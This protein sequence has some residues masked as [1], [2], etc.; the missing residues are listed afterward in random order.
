MTRDIHQEI[1]DRFIAAIEAG[2]KPWQADW[3]TTGLPLRVTGQAYQ[4]INTL[5]LGMIGAAK[6]YRN[7]TWMT[8]DQARK[9]GGCVRKGEKG[10][11]VVFYKQYDKNAAEDDA[12]AD[13][14]G[15][16][17]VRVLRG[18]T[19]FN[20]EQID[21][22]P[23]GK[24]AVA[25]PILDPMQ[26]DNDAESALR[27][28]GAD[29]REGGDRAYFDILADHVQLPEFVMFKSVGGYLATMA[30]ELVHWTGHKSRLGR[31]FGKQFGDATYA[32]EELV[33]EIGAAFVCARLGIAGDHFESHAAYVGSWLKKL[34]SDKKAIFRAAAL[35][36]AAADLVLA[37][38]MPASV[39]QD[40]QE[41]EP[42]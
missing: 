1:T 19:V 23:E 30:H 11:P 37:N 27:S 6:G 36:Q 42:A 22:L 39:D 24:F 7:P 31:E 3:I 28:C 14:D 16:V 29:I 4:G 41:V 12:R 32:F 10:S 5:L 38:A 13:D 26:R 18:Y 9:L 35:A 21:G 25:E 33:A 17:R 2:T 34:R 20:V 8:F 40:A 15:K